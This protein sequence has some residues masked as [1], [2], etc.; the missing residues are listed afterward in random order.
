MGQKEGERS[1]AWEKVL[2][3]QCSHREKWNVVVMF[4]RLGEETERC[5]LR[6]TNKSAPDLPKEVGH[7]DPK[8]KMEID[9]SAAEGKYRDVDG[10]SA[11]RLSCLGSIR[12]RP[13]VKPNQPASP[14]GSPSRA[15]S[16]ALPAWWPPFFFKFKLELG[17][18][19][20]H[21]L[22]LQVR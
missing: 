17:S 18:H 2:F 6:S 19:E 3:S 15:L 9:G 8:P 5:A 14:A 12:R 20:A 13:V 4:G 11:V 22:R 21:A 1:N 10:T 7:H 16:T